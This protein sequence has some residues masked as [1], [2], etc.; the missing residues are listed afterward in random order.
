MYN[1]TK[2]FC[3]YCLQ[4]FS[5]EDILTKHKTEGLVKK[6]RGGGGGVGR[7]MRKS[8][9]PKTHDPTPFMGIKFADPPPGSG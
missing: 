1:Q 7:S 3:V 5:S 8:E 6:Y 9:G 4:C 2:Y